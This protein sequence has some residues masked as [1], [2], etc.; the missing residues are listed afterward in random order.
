M[1]IPHELQEEF[2]AHA[3]LIERLRQ[4]DHEF[5]RLAARYDD[6]NQNI[7]RIESE[8]EPAEDTVAEAFKK[9]RLMLKDEIASFLVRVERRM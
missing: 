8:Q 7:H 6:V 4:T 1:H 2:R 9:E 5:G 3:G